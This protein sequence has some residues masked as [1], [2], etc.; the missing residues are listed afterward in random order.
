MLAVSV[1]LCSREVVKSLCFLAKI[2]QCE[3]LV[4]GRV[5]F[6]RKFGNILSVCGKLE[7]GVSQRYDE[8]KK[9]LSIKFS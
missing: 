8:L 5:A 2:S 7:L 1:F 4:A 9:I 3:C 6:E